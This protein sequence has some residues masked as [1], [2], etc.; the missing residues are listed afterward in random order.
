LEQAQI[1]TIGKTDASARRIALELRFDVTEERKRWWWKDGTHTRT[2]FVRTAHV[3]DDAIGSRVIV[4]EDE[5][6]RMCAS[7][8]SMPNAS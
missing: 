5:Q 7:T 8:T 2:R 4:I 1:A 3:L 6:Q